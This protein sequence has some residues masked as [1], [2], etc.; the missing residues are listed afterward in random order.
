MSHHKELLATKALLT[1][2][3]LTPRHEDTPPSAIL[4]RDRWSILILYSADTPLSAGLLPPGGAEYDAIPVLD[5]DRW[6]K[7]SREEMTLHTLGDRVTVGGRPGT[8]VGFR[9][10]EQPPAA[11]PWR[12]RLA[13][14]YDDGADGDPR[15]ASAAC[16]G[17]APAAAGE[18]RGWQCND[19]GTVM[20]LT[21]TYTRDDSAPMERKPLCDYHAHYGDRRLVVVRVLHQIPLLTTGKAT[22]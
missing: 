13:V 22:S 7:C 21:R 12:F 10:E 5:V 20:C 15:P 1:K 9:L 8:V 11:G 6:M 19:V 18:C 17:L 16:L 3:N 14:V 4:T 2:W